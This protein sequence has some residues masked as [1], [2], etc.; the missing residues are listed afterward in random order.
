MFRIVAFNNV[1]SG[2]RIAHKRGEKM[3]SLRIML[4]DDN[5]SF[6]NSALNF[7]NA[8]MKFESLSWASTGEEALEK[9]ESLQPSLI[10]MNS[11]MVENNGQEIIEIIRNLDKNA[12]IIFLT[13][14]KDFKYNK[15]LIRDADDFISKFEFSAHL[16]PKV[17]KIFRY[18]VSRDYCLFGKKK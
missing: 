14:D 17:E 7:I 4:V 6:R 10:L 18:K 2:M 9:I 12:V 15:S 8:Q 3:N 13:I 5:I 16:I 1:I 11:K